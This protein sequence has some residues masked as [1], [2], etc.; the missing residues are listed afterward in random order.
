MLVVMLAASLLS[1]EIV[2]PSARA[3]VG[4]PPTATPFGIFDQEPGITIIKR[5]CTSFG[6]N[7][8]DRD[9][10]L[11]GYSIDFDAFAGNSTDGVREHEF[12]VTLD[13]VPAQ[14]APLARPMYEVPPR[15]SVRASPATRA[16]SRPAAARMPKGA[17][18]Q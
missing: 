16:T 4:Q 7:D 5:V 9:Y 18:L 3:Q 17:S 13:Q 8:C 15:T 11:A 14:P 12:T 10:S 6:E 1:G 2:T